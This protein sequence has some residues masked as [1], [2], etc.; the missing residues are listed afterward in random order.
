[1]SLIDRIIISRGCF[2]SAS[3]DKAINENV[4]VSYR[5]QSIS[6]DRGATRNVRYS[7]GGSAPAELIDHGDR[8]RSATLP[9]PNI[10]M[11]LPQA[12]APM[13]ALHIATA[14]ATVTS[15]VSRYSL[16]MQNSPTSI[17]AAAF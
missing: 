16:P 8:S 12:L 13:A 17:F 7:N 15:P 4:P 2:T 5:K 11:V 6:P 14:G 1:M 9:L 3:I 10:L